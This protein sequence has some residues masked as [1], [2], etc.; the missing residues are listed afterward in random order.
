MRAVT[1]MFEKSMSIGE[2]LGEAARRLADVSETPRMDA[3]YLMAHALGIRRSD[4]LARLHAPTVPSA[5]EALLRRRLAYEP[6]PYIISEWEFYSLPIRCAP[7]TLVPRPETEHLVEAVLDAA[8]NAPVRMLELGTGTGCVAMALAHNLPSAR[9][10]ATDR[11][12][13]AIALAR[14]NAARLRLD[15]RIVLLQGD[16]YHPLR[17]EDAN[18]DVICSNPPYVEEGLWDSLSRSIRDYEDP[19]AVLSGPDGLDM[20]RALVAGAGDFLR[21][22]GFLAMEIGDGQAHAV[23][24]ILA[25]HEFAAITFVN[26]LAGIRRI[27]TARKPV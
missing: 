7:P 19:R 18:F 13:E 24:E 11:A 12:P 10:V 20:I 27:A 14:E 23:G 6:I 16:L 17:P 9:I 25:A 21:P 4:L 3:E 15:A 8:G 2:C 5:F 1:H 26:D 22:G